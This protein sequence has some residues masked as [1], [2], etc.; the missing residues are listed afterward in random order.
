MHE[1]TL[2][3]I[4]VDLDAWR[5]PGS[6]SAFSTM[7]RPTTARVEHSLHFL[8]RVTFVY[9]AGGTVLQDVY[10][11]WMDREG[12]FTHLRRTP[13]QYFSPVFS[14]DGKH[15]A[16]SVPDGGRNDIWV[17]AWE[18][19]TLTRLTFD[20]ESNSN[21]AWTPDGR[22]VTYSSVEKGSQSNI[23][24]KRAD[25][26]GEVMQLTNSKNAKNPYSWRA[27][28][29]VLAFTELNPQTRWDIMTLSV[30]RQ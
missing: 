22:R 12:K 13:A 5:R 23:Y 7:S 3:D 26:G 17:Y 11:D 25:G 29:K 19:D 27:D 4:P 20:G 28:G 9:L 18:R 15:L 30:A 6:P 21:P 14:P 10:L 8:K 24:W 2:L 16:F 1:G